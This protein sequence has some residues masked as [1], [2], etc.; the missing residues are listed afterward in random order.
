MRAIVQFTD[1]DLRLADVNDAGLESLVL[2]ALHDLQEACLDGRLAGGPD[3][4]EDDSDE[5]RRGACAPDLEDD[6]H[7]N[8]CDS[9]DESGGWQ[10]VGVETL[11]AEFRRRLLATWALSVPLS[12]NV[13]GQELRAARR[14]VT[15]WD[16]GVDIDGSTEWRA[17]LPLGALWALVVEAHLPD[18]V[19]FDEGDTL[20]LSIVRVDTDV[21][22]ALDRVAVASIG[23]PLKPQK[24][25]A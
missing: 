17:V 5:D 8:P 3:A 14:D 25:A 24:R 12:R 15:H 7:G 4:G 6:S 1:T 23:R 21:A 9:G 10:R 13:V 16:N 18:G 11:P 19:Y 20:H 2:S 22:E